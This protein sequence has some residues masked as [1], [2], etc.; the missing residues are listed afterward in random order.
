MLLYLC[1]L[2][3]NIHHFMHIVFNICVY[4]GIFIHHCEE[5]FSV[6]CWGGIKVCNRFVELRYGAVLVVFGSM[7]SSLLQQHFHYI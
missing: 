5:F 2:D 4:Y 7:V 1:L 3:L 6:R